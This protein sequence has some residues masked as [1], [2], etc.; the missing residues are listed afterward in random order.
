MQDE[1][2]RYAG[3]RKKTGRFYWVVSFF[4]I[5]L[6]PTLIVFMGC[7]AVYPALT[8]NPAGIG[9]IDVI[10]AIITL[11]AITI[12]TVADRQLRKFI[13]NPSSTFLNSGLWKYSRHPNYFGEVLFWT[14]LWIFSL[15]PLT[16]QSIVVLRWWTIPGP[17]IMIL[18]FTFLSVPM[19]D[20][21]MLER[22]AEY[23]DYMKR[24][25]GLVPWFK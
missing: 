10:A 9:I 24:T 25:S 16:P 17:V 20:R 4:G 12:E 14:G 22:K 13:D 11:S 3:Y 5:H 21:H 8:A 23:K 7:V 18:L 2:W 1:D 15:S 6:F 19:M